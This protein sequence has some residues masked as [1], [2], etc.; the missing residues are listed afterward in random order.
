MSNPFL[1]GLGKALSAFGLELSLKSL[2]LVP[3]ACLREGGHKAS[4]GVGAKAERSPEPPSLPVCLWSC[5]SSGGRPLLSSPTTC[6]LTPSPGWPTSDP[7]TRPRPPILT[8]ASPP[9][10]PGPPRGQEHTAGG[11]GARPG[12]ARTQAPLCP[13][14]RFRGSGRARAPR[15]PRPAARPGCATCTR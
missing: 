3:G 10:R 7:L 12:P 15:A 1:C 5:R 2:S 6:P 14:G 8:P 4:Y 9:P 13:S 11:R